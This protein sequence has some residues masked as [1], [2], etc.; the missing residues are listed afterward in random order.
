[1]RRQYSGPT[2]LLIVLRLSS[3]LGARMQVIAEL[4]PAETA[5]RDV[6]YDGVNQI[7]LAWNRM[8]PRWGLGSG[9][10]LDVGR[11]HRRPDG[12][13]VVE[14]AVLFRVRAAPGHGR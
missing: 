14:R 9:Y 8:G 1:M 7:Q 5:R 10:S 12:G 4:L 2:L 13:C 6:R 11:P 3:R